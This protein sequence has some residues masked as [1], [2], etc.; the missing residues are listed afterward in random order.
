MRALSSR[1]SQCPRAAPGSLAA[2]RDALAEL[3][4]PVRLVLDDFHAVSGGEVAADLEWLIEHVP[5]RLR[6]IV[7]TRSDP[8]LRLQRLR[9]AGRLTE[10]R[11][12]DLAF[13]RSEAS[14]LLAP[15]ELPAG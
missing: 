15:L 2:L 1:A 7:A 4:E 10:I 5:D 14:E 6:L 9:V 13:T 3:D 8:P 12:A 11:A